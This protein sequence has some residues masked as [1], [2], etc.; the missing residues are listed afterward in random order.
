M[1]EMLSKQLMTSLREHAASCGRPN[2]RNGT[3]DRLEE[4]CDAIAS[5]KA[6][7]LI[8]RVLPDLAFR[9]RRPLVI[10]RPARIEEYVQARRLADGTAKRLPSRW[11][12]PT[13]ITIRK[14]ARLLEYVKTRAA[15]QEG[16]VAAK[17]PDSAESMLSSVPDLSLRAELR[18][19][20]AK[21]HQ[22]QQDLLRLREAMRLLRVPSELYG[23]SETPA[24]GSDIAVPADTFLAEAVSIAAQVLGKLTTTQHLVRCGLEYV[25]EVGNVVERRTRYELLTADDIQALRRIAGHRHRSSPA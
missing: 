12:G 5:G 16:G 25:A 13:A 4:A 21:G 17:V 23:A 11:T 2:E 24:L 7:G 10:I 22:A 14:D 18:L 1:S 15:E 9:Y 8:D 20:L 3:L 19:R 6:A